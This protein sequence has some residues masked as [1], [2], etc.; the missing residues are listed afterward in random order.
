M[1]SSPYCLCD[2]DY[3]ATI[4]LAIEN[5]EVYIQWYIYIYMYLLYCYIIIYAC[6]VLNAMCLFLMVENGW[7]NMHI[8]YIW[9]VLISYGVNVC[10]ISWSNSKH[11]QKR[12]CGWIITRVI[13]WTF[14]GNA[15]NFKNNSGCQKN[16][17][18]YRRMQEYGAAFRLS[19]INDAIKIIL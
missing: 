16:F 8:K 11:L 13:Y 7:Q 12:D 17:F 3:R 5:I 14:T 2:C 10:V 1:T 4:A 19:T 6:N 15:I 9:F 18:L